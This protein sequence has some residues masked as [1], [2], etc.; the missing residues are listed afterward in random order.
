M[1]EQIG[2][3]LMLQ[4]LDLLISGS[5]LDSKIIELINEVE[6]I[7]QIAMSDRKKLFHEKWSLKDRI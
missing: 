2:R 3:R 4:I 1:E 6:T 7:C 5:F